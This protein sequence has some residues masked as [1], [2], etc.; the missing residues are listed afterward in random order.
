MN[1][2]QWRDTG[3]SELLPVIC[4]GVVILP[5]YVLAMRIVSQVSV[6]VR[7]LLRSGRSQPVLLQRLGVRG[8][9]GPHKTHTNV[10][11]CFQ[12]RTSV[13]AENLTKY[14]DKNTK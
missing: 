14:R 8:Q 12:F 7:N 2:K 6:V 4:I 10:G 9:V 13:G 11:I 5:T 3:L 1:E